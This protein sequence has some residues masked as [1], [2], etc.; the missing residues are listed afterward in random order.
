[1]VGPHVQTRL[2]ESDGPG[3]D[4]I[5]VAEDH[6]RVT[7]SSRHGRHPARAQSRVA[8]RRRRTKS[9][10]QRQHGS[11][12]QHQTALRSCHNTFSVPVA[13]AISVY[14]IS[15]Y[16]SDRKNDPHHEAEERAVRAGV[17]AAP[18]GAGSCSACSIRPARRRRAKALTITP[19]N[20]DET[21]YRQLRAG[22]NEAVVRGVPAHTNARTA[23]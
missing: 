2:T 21:G 22:L 1:M 17:N 5:V 7:H 18:S 11:F 8:E 14:N 10:A 4:D 20:N 13:N 19:V 16:G 15:E 23:A 3:R 12:P 6:A 9:V